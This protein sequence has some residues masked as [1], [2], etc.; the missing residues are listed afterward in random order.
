VAFADI[1]VICLAGQ[2]TVFDHEGAVAAAFPH[3]A[4]ASV[5]ALWQAR[6]FEYAVLAA[7][8]GRAP[9]AWA[10]AGQA[11][12]HAMAAHGLTDALLRGKL[13][14]ALLQPL[15]CA[16]VAAA[17]PL[18][19]AT[20]RRLVLLSD[21]SS[22]MLISQAKS[23]GVFTSFDALLTTE[24]SGAV[25]PQA[26]AYH[27]LAQRFGVQPAQVLYASARAW[28]VAGASAAGL[29]TVW[30]NRAGLPPEHAWAPPFATVGGL[31]EVASLLPPPGATA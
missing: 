20:G 23:A 13:M 22:I 24:P 21:A 10:L 29:T 27:M 4:A 6:R 31:A 7:L 3:A 25:K 8:T 26:D 17:L 11:L 30:L 15:P 2:G 28:D 9:D 1:K 14:Q 12:D 5:V 19:R 18:L 16:D